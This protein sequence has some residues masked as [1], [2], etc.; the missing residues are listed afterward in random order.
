MGGTS[1]KVY[2][3]LQLLQSTPQLVTDAIMSDS[4]AHPQQESQVTQN[5]PLTVPTI[6]SEARPPQ[7][8]V[9]QCTDLA[10]L[11]TTGSEAQTDW[12]FLLRGATTVTR[13]ARAEAA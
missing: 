13:A 10:V 3:L 4:S 6:G 12:V 11:P 2:D 8:P 7:P 5:Q 9:V 1:G